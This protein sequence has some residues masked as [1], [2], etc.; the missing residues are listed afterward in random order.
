[1]KY[2]IQETNECFDDYE[3][4]ID[5][6]IEDDYHEDDDYFEEWVNNTYGY[7]EIGG[8]R[9]YAYDILSAMNESDLDCLM[10][11]Y[12]E[13]ENEDDR[14]RAMYDLRHASGGDEICVQR[15]TIEVIDDEAGDYD[16][17][18]GDSIETVRKFV[19]E[20]KIIQDIAISEER[21]AENDLMSMFQ[22]IK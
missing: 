19:E 8:E 7:L 5:A 12:C 13:N 6:C 3:E 4:A 10:D 14:E 9:Y 22:V 17:D 16:G 2:C 15:Y 11:D 18:D 21:K 20:Q 1:M